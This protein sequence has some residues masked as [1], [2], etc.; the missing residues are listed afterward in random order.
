MT[1]EELFNVITKNKLKY[2]SDNF[3]KY[4]KNIVK[5]KF[6]GKHEMV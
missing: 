1:P 6:D 3:V 5:D 4:V 2:I